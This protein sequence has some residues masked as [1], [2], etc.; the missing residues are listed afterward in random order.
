MFTNPTNFRYPFTYRFCEKIHF[1]TQKQH[2]NFLLIIKHDF[3]LLRCVCVCKKGLLF[4]ISLREDIRKD[5]KMWE[6]DGVYV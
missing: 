2:V 6:N 1:Y 4:Y 5:T 3:R